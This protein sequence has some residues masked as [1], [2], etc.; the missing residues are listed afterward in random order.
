MAWHKGKSGNPT[1]RPKGAKN[2]Y[3]QIL[4]DFFDVWQ[5]EDCVKRLKQHI[6]DP[7]NFNKFVEVIARLM[8]RQI[9]H[10]GQLDSEVSIRDYRSLSDDELAREFDQKIRAARLNLIGPGTSSN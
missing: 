8:P 2:R 10:S 3:T 1:G 4:N 7:A 9:E 5:Q 6:Q